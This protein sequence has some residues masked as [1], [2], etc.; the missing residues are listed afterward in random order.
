MGKR[1]TQRTN[2]QSTS[3]G[4]NPPQ[5]ANEEHTHKK[6]VAAGRGP[7]RQA[8]QRSQDNHER[9]PQAWRRK[10]NDVSHSRTKP[11]HIKKGRRSR[12]TTRAVVSSPDTSEDSLSEGRA[13]QLLESRDDNTFGLNEVELTELLMN[14]EVKDLDVVVVSLVGKFR[15]GKSFLL[16][17]FLRW[18]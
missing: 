2:S 5:G 13:I 15:K 12:R 14:D 4:D 16:D 18:G 11:R 10:G 6:E 9:Q 7:E 17:F 8:P 1:K 3:S